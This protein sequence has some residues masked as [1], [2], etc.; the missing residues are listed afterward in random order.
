MFSEGVRHGEG[1]CQSADGTVYSGFWAGDQRSGMGECVLPSGDSYYG[2]WEGDEK[3]GQGAY[4]YKAKGRIY[5]GE[6][7]RGVPRA[8]EMRDFAAQQPSSAAAAA[9]LGTTAMPLLRLLDPQGVL[10]GACLS[11]SGRL[12]EELEG[13]GGAAGGR[14]GTR[15]SADTGYSTGFSEIM[16]Y[17][18]GSRPT[19]SSAE[20]AAGGSGGGGFAY[21]PSLTRENLE[22]LAAA[23]TSV[24]VNN[25]GFIPADPA[26]LEYIL[27]QLS[28]DPPSE[29]D[30]A[31][32]LE[33]L[34]AQTQGVDAHE[35]GAARISFQSFV[36]AMGRVKE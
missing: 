25:T 9:A 24:D 34:V 5:E 1:R 11:A 3:H 21:D 31:G 19:T 13:G 6:W 36:A 23:F 8:G 22:V 12:G 18:T 27:Q 33:E 4:V 30:L 28:I 29:E 35:G 14:A 17:G 7:V 2:S 26:A 15:G 32:L 16:T 10:V 20:G